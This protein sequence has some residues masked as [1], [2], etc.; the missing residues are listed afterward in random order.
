MSKVQRRARSARPTSFSGRAAVLCPPSSAM[1]YDAERISICV[2]LCLSMANLASTETDEQKTTRR[3]SAGL[4]FARKLCGEGLTA[5]SNAAAATQGI[6]PQGKQGQCVRL[7][8]RRD[9]MLS[10]PSRPRRSHR[11][12][13]RWNRHPGRL[14]SRLGSQNWPSHWIG[15]AHDR[16]AREVQQG[17]PIKADGHF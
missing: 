17:L 10:N 14:E 9:A 6:L 15:A 3:L 4:V 8:H 2:H 12:S 11:R 7:R 13:S 5:W 1:N 16:L